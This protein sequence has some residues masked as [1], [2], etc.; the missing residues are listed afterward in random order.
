MPM[1]AP[2]DD[3]REDARVET[4][5]EREQRARLQRRHACDPTCGC[6]R[7]APDVTLNSDE[8]PQ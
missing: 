6:T 5:E 7:R 4:M 8:E 1:R 3:E 2:T